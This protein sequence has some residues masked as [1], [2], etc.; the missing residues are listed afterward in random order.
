LG[1]QFEEQVIGQLASLAVKRDQCPGG[2]VG[3]MRL[4]ES[5]P[6]PVQWWINISSP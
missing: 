2:I 5:L 1:G 3:A 6:Q 4:M